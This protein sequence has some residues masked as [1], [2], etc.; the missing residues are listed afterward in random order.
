MRK[1]DTKSLILTLFGFLFSI[2]PPMI[3]TLA[4]FP[5]WKD[6][7]GA[8]LISGFALLLLLLSFL[9][10]MRFIKEKLK[11][12][13]AI[14]IWA[15]IYCLFFALSRIAD[16]VTVIAF[17]GLIGN[18]IGAFFFHLAKRRNKSL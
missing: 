16:Q 8:Y 4:Y 7:G 1:T 10:M 5:L 14:L 3:S 17:F 18:I 6:A 13:S 12:P 2:L 15:L 11:S 9:P